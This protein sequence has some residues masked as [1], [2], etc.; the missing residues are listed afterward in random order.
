MTRDY[1]GGAGGRAPEP[2]SSA[3]GGG[4]RVLDAGGQP[5]EPASSARGDGRRVRARRVQ[6]A[7]RWRERPAWA[8]GRARG[9][10]QAKRCGRGG[11]RGGAG[12]GDFGAAAGGRARRARARRAGTSGAAREKARRREDDGQGGGRRWQGR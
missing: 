2:A 6:V 8:G 5:R 3:R 9:G 10:A 4:H 11:V 7:G 12:G 1:L